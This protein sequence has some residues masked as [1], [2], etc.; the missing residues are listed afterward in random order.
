[1][2]TIRGLFLRAD[3]AACLHPPETRANGLWPRLPNGR[4]TRII[5]ESWG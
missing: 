2:V 3:N 1:M 4:F 5:E